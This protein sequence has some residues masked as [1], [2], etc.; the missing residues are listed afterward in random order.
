[1]AAF[2]VEELR[3]A[4]AA[5]SRGQLDESRRLCSAI[6][7]RRSDWPDA[8]HLSAAIALHSGDPEGALSQ[9]NRAIDA[10]PGDASFHQTRAH[11]LRMLG[12]GAQAESEFRRALALAPGL[13]EAHAGLAS[14][15]IDRREWTGARDNLA[16]AV[17]SR[18]GNA[19]WRYNL[20]LC[21]MQL[22][23]LDAAAAQLRAALQLAPGWPQAASLLGVVLMQ[24]GDAEGAAGALESALATDP[25]LAPAWNNLGT[26]RLAQGR[27]EE[28]KRCFGEAIALDPRDAQ[29]AGNLGNAQRASGDLAAAERAYRDAIRIAP[30]FGTA[31]QNLGNVLREMGRIPEARAALE[32]AVR[33][34]DSPEAHMSLAITMLSSGDVPAA[35]TEYAWRHGARPRAETVN[36]LRAAL[37]SGAPV[38]LRSEQGLGD[39]LFFLRW[40]PSIPSS[41]RA[42]RGD[43]R[44]AALLARTGLFERIEP[45]APSQDAVWIGDLPG[46]LDDRAPAFLPPLPLS[47][48]PAALEAAR[49]EL[50]A[51]GP[52]PYVGVVW[53]SGTPFQSGDERL[54]KNAPLEQLGSA[55]AATQGTIVS[56]QRR[57][58]AGE[59]ERLAAACAR[60]VFDA[61]AWN[62]DLEKITAAI[63]LLSRYVGVSSTNLHIAAGLGT[64][65]SI[66]VPQPPEW[67]FGTGGTSTPWFPGATVHRQAADGSWDAAFGTLSRELASA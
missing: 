20:A 63:A 10:H 13:P 59:L 61:S 50:E 27:V 55:L 8:L 60:P 48:D 56:L 65:A 23:N 16:A 18:S 52:S 34:S 17:S 39:M 42:W 49:R 32:E 29:A 58:A 28:A 6:L 46:L 15:L 53:R 44:L 3:Q 11:V 38:A 1:V 37:T 14:C 24:K 40:A 66:L 36:A 35:W 5:F 43:A 7:S 9:V 22:G 31:W 4:Q 64:N 51:F 12:R 21:E 30:R 54:S 2:G 33:A 57:P 41:H 26:V 25:K 67:R 47:A 45:E 19:P 62:D